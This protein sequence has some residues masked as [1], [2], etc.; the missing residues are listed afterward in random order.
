VDRIIDRL[1]L[2]PYANKRAGTLSRGN[3]QRLGLAKALLHDPRLLLLDEPM[4]GL[5][6]AGI[7]EIRHLLLSLASEQGVTI[8]LS[9]HILSEVSRLAQRIGIIH[10]GRL[11]QELSPTDLHRHR[12]RR[13]LV[14][15]RD[16]RAACDVLTA[17]GYSAELAPDDTIRVGDDAAVEH[18]D[19]VATHLFNAGHA[20]T[21]FNVEEEALEHYFL[22]L[23]GMEGGSGT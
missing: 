9:S 18:P 13:L 7:V 10:E 16:S 5:D 21:M 17:A 11:I 2:A 15:T 8:F 1:G 22:R 6:P 14:R 23:V 19:T 4:N 20:P 12:H 3:A